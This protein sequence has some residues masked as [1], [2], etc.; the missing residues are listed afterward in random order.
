[1]K[2]PQSKIFYWLPPLLWMAAI[3]VFSTDNFSGENTGGLFFKIFHAIIP[4]LTEEKFGFLHFLIRKVAHFTEYAILA[5]F[6]F[7]AFR[8]GDV[9]KWKRTWAFY[10]ILSVVA[11]SLLDEYHQTWTAHRV[12]SIYDSLIDCL[13]GIAA[14][15]LLW[16]LRSPRT[17]SRR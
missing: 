8:S 7:R 6:L 4:G 5:L 3:F 12:G 2:G 13:G 1:L 10:S 16:L 11:Y 14:M 9:V 17:L 15:T